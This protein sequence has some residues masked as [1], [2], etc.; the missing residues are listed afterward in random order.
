MLKLSAAIFLMISMPPCVAQD[1][2]WPPACVVE[3]MN[4][5]TSTDGALEVR[6]WLGAGLAR[7][8]TLYRVRQT[9]EGVSGSRI[10]W[11]DRSHL[12]NALYTEKSARRQTSRDRRFLEKHYCE[13]ETT[14]SA[15]VMWCDWPIDREVLWDV[16][17]DDLL[18]EQLWTLPAKIPRDCGG[19][20]EDGEAV[21]IE[22]IQG[23]RRHAVTYG[24]PDF[25]CADVAC[26]IAN[27][28]RQVLRAGT[29]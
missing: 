26:A 22:V 14:Q 10:A 11:T 25:C 21:G 8:Y 20:M 27:H 18:P 13:A 1:A 6:V 5:P 3:E 9:P 4:L 12:F 23:N 2:Y 16:L 19:A 15:N 24:N 28:V 29:R 7:P 17:L